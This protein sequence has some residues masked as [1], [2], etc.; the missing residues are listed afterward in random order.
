MIEFM[1]PKS[2]IA[3]THTLRIFIS[4]PISVIEQICRQACLQDPICVT[5]EP[6]KFIYTGGEEA[7]AVIG[8]LNYPRFPRSAEEIN[9]RAKSLAIKLLEGT[10]QRNALIVTN[11]KTELIS[12][13]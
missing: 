3:D 8:L 11:E 13:F 6:T 12:A 5:V 4:G 9:I 1:N 7:G 2:T 10:H